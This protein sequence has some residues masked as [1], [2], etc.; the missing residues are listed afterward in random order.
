LKILINNTYVDLCNYFMKDVDRDVADK[1][2]TDLFVK[3]ERLSPL[4]L[5][6]NTQMTFLI[7]ARS[8]DNDIRCVNYETYYSGHGISGNIFLTFL[9]KMK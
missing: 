2:W 3:I 4:N 7:A 6:N 5:I 1:V 9:K 8:N